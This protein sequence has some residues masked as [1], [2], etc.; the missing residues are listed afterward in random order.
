LAFYLFESMR[1]F[2]LIFHAKFAQ[3]FNFLHVWFLT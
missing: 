3:F 2:C 1:K